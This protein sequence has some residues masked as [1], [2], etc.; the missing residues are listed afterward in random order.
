MIG[1]QEDVY[2]YITVLNENYEHPA[3]PEGAE[4]GIVKGMYLLKAA[5]VRRPRATRSSSWARA[6][7]CAR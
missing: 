5:D 2:Y 7:S 1:E 6:P 3:M 4:E